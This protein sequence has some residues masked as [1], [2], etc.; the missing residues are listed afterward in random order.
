MFWSRSRPFED[1]ARRSGL[2]FS[3]GGRLLQ[4][5]WSSRP[6]EVRIDASRVVVACRLDAP[7]EAT[8]PH[9]ARGL[10]SHIRSVDRRLALPTPSLR[11]DRVRLA[12]ARVLEAGHVACIR[13][14]EIQIRRRRDATSEL[15][16]S[17][18]LSYAVELSCC[19]GPAV[20]VRRAA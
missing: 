6:V 9:S 1:F 8:F 15:D 19:M 14:Q 2:E 20:G 13:G 5:L 10:L 7:V 3:D 16:L 18:S 4:G 12:W 17:A 11:D